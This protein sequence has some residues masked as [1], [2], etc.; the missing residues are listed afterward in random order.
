MAADKDR[1]ELKI[2]KIEIAQQ[3]VGTL[4]G[5]RPLNSLSFTLSENGVDAVIETVKLVEWGIGK[6]KSKIRKAALDILKPLAE[7]E[8]AKPVNVNF[9]EPE[10]KSIG[11]VLELIERALEKHKDGVLSR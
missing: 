10:V 11:E 2:D 3:I 6:N 9:T 7:S 4:A 1:I 5:I 8:P